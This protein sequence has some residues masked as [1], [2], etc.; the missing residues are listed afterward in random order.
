MSSRFISLKRILVLSLLLTVGVAGHSETAVAKKRFKN[1]SLTRLV[2]WPS[3]TTKIGSTLFR[4]T[5]YSEL[6]GFSEDHGDT[7]LAYNRTS[8]RTVN[9]TFGGKRWASEQDYGVA[10]IQVLVEGIPMKEYLVPMDSTTTVNKI[11]LK[12]RRSA[13][14]R[15]KMVTDYTDMTV[16]VNGTA[17]CYSSNGKA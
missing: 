17:S 7:M 11:R 12:P 14:I 4:Y 5:W 13:V 8:C 6:G 10:Y 1:V 3:K 15:T 9:L 2:H 16:Y